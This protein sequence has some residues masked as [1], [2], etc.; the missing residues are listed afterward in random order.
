MVNKKV[1]SSLLCLGILSNVSLG[2]VTVKASSNAAN[3]SL[4]RTYQEIDGFGVSQAAWSNAIY[5]M[6]EPA[7]SEI[8]DLLFTEEGIDLDIFRGEIF[9][10]FAPALGEYDFTQRQD[11]A[12]VMKEAKARG[13]DKIVATTW[14]PPAWMKTNNQTTHGGYLKKEYYDEYADLMAEFVKQYKSLYD[15]DLYAVSLTN[16]PNS[17]TFLTWDSC[18]WTGEQ[19]KDFLANYLKPE[20]EAEGLDQVKVIAAEPSWWSEDMMKPA[21]NDPV[22][23]SRIDIVGAHNY[24]IP[25]L[26]IKQPQTPFT[27]A[28]SKGKKVWMTEVSSTGTY[29]PGMTSGL[30]FAKEMHTF[31][32]KVGANAY[33]YWTGAIPGDNDEGLINVD[34]ESSTYKL[35]KRYHAFGNFGKFIK[36]GYERIEMTEN[37]VSGVY[38]SAY[39]DP[40][41]DEV[42]IV[43][44]NE[45][46][47]EKAFAI[48]PADFYT[49]ELTPY[50]T[51][52]TYDLERL[53]PIVTSKGAFEVTIPARSIVTY[54][55]TLEDTPVPTVETFYDS[56][57]NWDNVYHYTTGAAID[58]SSPNKFNKDGARVKR[59]TEDTE[60][61]VYQVEG[62]ESFEATLYHNAEWDGIAFYSSGDGENWTRVPHVS[63]PGKLVSI[64]WYSKTYSSVPLLTKD[65]NYLKIE[66]SGPGAWNKQIGDVTIKYR[67]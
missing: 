31:M 35:T 36:P 49:S 32:T 41:Q 43:A 61:I 28:Q 17:M 25:I 65:N 12:W 45:S 63:T 50:I 38:T 26:N 55:G 7:R 46:N 52:E 66:L 57:D 44:I 11:Q 18:E 6:E 4:N 10:D 14:S 22:A 27:V 40:S 51:S 19:I 56:L 3:V 29:D 20:F 2:G 48:N 1:L 9:P 47:E 21:L 8:M 33:L 16:E 67:K 23:S 62:I 24:K 37:P 30:E 60:S 53:K 39:T 13:V 34:L 42:V 15:L 64:G 5:D 59:L 54:V 58:V